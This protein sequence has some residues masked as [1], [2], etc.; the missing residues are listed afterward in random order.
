VCILLIG[1]GGLGAQNLP[2]DPVMKARAER[3]QSQGIAEGDLPPVPRG[4][5]EPPPLPPPET[6]LKDTRGGGRVAKAKGHAK[7]TKSARGGKAAKGTRTAKGTTAAPGKHPAKG[8]RKSSK[9]VKA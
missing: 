7:G 6:H 2:V 3:A 5:V 8:G 1:F 4:I 9:R